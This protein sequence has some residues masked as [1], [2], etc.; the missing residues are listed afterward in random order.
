MFNK[1]LIS[2]LL[3]GVS[4]SAGIYDNT[5]RLAK[6]SNQTVTQP[7]DFYMNGDFKEI[8]RFDALDFN[9]GMDNKAINNTIK[10][11]KSYDKKNN[12][13]HISIIGHT[14]EVTDDKNEKTVDSKTYANKIENWF[15]ASYDTNES[16]QDSKNYALQ[17]E[18]QMLDNNISKDIIT[19]EYRGGKDLG[20]SDATSRGIDLS[21]RVMVTMYVSTDMYVDD[22]KD[23]VLDYEDDCLDT[24]K[25]VKVDVRGCA[26]DGD[27][28]GIADYIDKCLET[29]R[30]VKV[31]ENGCSLDSDK[32]G[33]L[34]Y[35]DV[36]PDTPLDV[37]VDMRGCALKSTLKI[38]FQV[39]S[40][41]ILSESIPE[42]ERFATFMK[43]N[44]MAHVKITGH[45]DS[46]G[47]ATANM[48]LSKNRAIN[49][50]AAL[51]AQ[52]VEVSRITTGGRGEL[53]PIQNNR[54]KEGRKANR[55]IEVEL[56]YEK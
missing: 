48:L 8:V 6:E 19:L 55:R 22:D 14:Q 39:G 50:K 10:Q 15:R 53:D 3:L 31:D 41:K 46:I 25:G 36:C 37:K 21:N 38:F 51:V 52:G 24:P 42:I 56:T 40:D 11:I 1:I 23:K 9:D 27:Y 33:V 29:P 44:P 17:V 47:K 45:T 12:T 30:A 2:I 32:D 34:D 18:K 5:Y 4:L 16:K 20:F 49:T 54:T 35:T 43:E 26:L 7:S 28:D 13:I